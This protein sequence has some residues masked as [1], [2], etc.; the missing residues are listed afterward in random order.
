MSS[1]SK[2]DYERTLHRLNRF[3]YWTD[4]NIRVPF[5]NFRFGL[6]P[7]VGLIPGIGDFTGLILSF[8]VLYEARKAGV[9]GTIQR[10]MIR[11]ILI[12]FFVGLLPVLGDAFD[13]VYKANTRNTELLRC[14]L[15]KELGKE[16][17]Q[18]FPW[19]TFIY[20]SMAIF[21]IGWLIYLSF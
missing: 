20:I 8:Y 10:K 5:T 9:P 3:S 4:N 6:S 17:P 2:T 16:S 7:L 19:F 11:T 13:A 21:L 14:Y 12:E 15:H 1:L 18:K